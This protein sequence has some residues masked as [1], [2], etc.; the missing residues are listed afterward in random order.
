MVLFKTGTKCWLDWLPIISKEPR[1]VWWALSTTPRQTVTEGQITG[2]RFLSISVFSWLTHT[3]KT[4][5]HFSLWM[6]ISLHVRIT[7]C[8]GILVV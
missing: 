6:N 8:L 7:F 5:P 2:P 3:I 4:I 1:A